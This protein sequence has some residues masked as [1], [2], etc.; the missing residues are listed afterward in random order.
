MP[1]LSQ[2]VD[3]VTA[4]LPTFEMGKYDSVGLAQLYPDYEFI[5]QFV[6]ARK[7]LE[8]TSYLI[9]TSLEIGAPSSF[10]ASYTNHPLQTSAPRLL[11]RI[12]TPLCKART[13]TTFSEDEKELQGASPTKIV[14]VVQT[15]LNKWR[16]DMIEGL[17]HQLLSTPASPDQ[18]PDVLR[19]LNYWMTDKS[20]I[21]VDT[22]DMNGGDDPTGHTAGAG[23][24]TK[25][26]ESRWPNAVAKFSKISQDSFFD[27]VEQFLNRVRMHS[28]IPHPSVAP[29]VPSRLIY[30]QEPIKRACSRFLAASNDDVGNDAGVY[31]DASFYKS[32]PIVIWHAMSDPA[33]PVRPSV[34]TAKLVD[35]NTFMYQVHSAFD[36][37]ISGPDK[38]PNVPGQMVM[39][40]ELWHALHCVRRD[41]NLQM[42]TDT[43]EL[44]PSSS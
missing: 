36:Q 31:R 44:Q 2:I 15:R 4:T 3:I 10:E 6:Q 41:R 13:S 27:L 30:V 14:D 29:E 11:K 33:S 34:G 16:R 21:S 22:L 35:W 37:K 28:A 17:E 12:Q 43:L 18:V 8:D 7:R 39:V 26:A 38:L 23:G 32:I 19:G 42:T 25:A 9:D 1:A 40:N 5:K 20:G 24:I